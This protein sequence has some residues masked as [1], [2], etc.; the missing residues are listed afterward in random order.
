MAPVDSGMSR[1]TF[2]RPSVFGAAIQPIVYVDGVPTQR[3]KPRGAFTVDVPKGTHRISATTEVAKSI[4]VDTTNASS[5]YVKCSIG[6]GV[7][8]GR[9]HF[10]VV[11]AQIGQMES[12]SLARVTQ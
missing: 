1:L 2:Y 9:P 3:C 7:M 10:E 5:A 4:R 6:L 11:D 8:A 12:A